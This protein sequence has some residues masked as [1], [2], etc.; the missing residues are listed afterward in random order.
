ML[1]VSASNV[2]Q[3]WL[4]SIADPSSRWTAFCIGALGKDEIFAVGPIWA[5]IC[6]I[7]VL[8][9]SGSSL[10]LFALSWEL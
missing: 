10:H 8:L 3:N 9:A 6:S 7:K 4:R 5:D 2:G 1:R